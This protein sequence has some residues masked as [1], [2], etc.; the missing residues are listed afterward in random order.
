MEVLRAPFRL[1]ELGSK[2]ELARRRKKTPVEISGTDGFARYYTMDCLG[3]DRVKLIVTYSE[4]RAKEI[5]DAYSFF[6][7]NILYYPAKDVLFYSAD[8]HGHT[9]L[10]QRMEVLKS[11]IEED[12]STVVVSIDALLNKVVPLEEI[13][14]IQ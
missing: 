10:R 12:I 5:L 11:I 9:I 6:D 2:C 7:K 8:I 3:S 4:D 1:S 14:I 13:K